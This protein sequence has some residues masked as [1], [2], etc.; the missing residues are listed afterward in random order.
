MH[1][2]QQHSLQ[3]EAEVCREANEYK[4]RGHLEALTLPAEQNH[5]INNSSTSKSETLLVE[6]LPGG[7]LNY[8]NYV[9][10]DVPSKCHVDE[11]GNN[12]PTSSGITL[13]KYDTFLGFVYYFSLF[14]YMSFS[15]YPNVE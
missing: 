4:S 13:T 6:A 14:I 10:H 7:S 2:Q 9:P 8:L 3:N 11:R 15:I 12:A 1:Q 5:T